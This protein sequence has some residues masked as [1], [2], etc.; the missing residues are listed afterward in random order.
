VSGVLCEVQVR[1]RECCTVLS[2]S[3][4]K[5]SKKRFGR[6]RATVEQLQGEWIIIFYFINE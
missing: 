3:A 5:E 2:T 6:H 4:T 1:F